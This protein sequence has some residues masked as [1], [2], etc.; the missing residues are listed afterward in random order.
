MTMFPLRGHLGADVYREEDHIKYRETY[1][2]ETKRSE[3]FS[4][5]DTLMLDFSPLKL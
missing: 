4:L 1:K 5:T 2:P 3:E